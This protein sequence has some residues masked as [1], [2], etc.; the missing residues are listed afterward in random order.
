[1]IT[2][3]TLHIRCGSD[4]REALALGGIPGDYLE[5]SDPVCQGPLPPG[6]VDSGDA[7]IERR[8]ISSPA[9]TACRLAKPFAS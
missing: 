3:D 8:A 6:M 2:P 7:L 5:F 4:I 9:S 1:M